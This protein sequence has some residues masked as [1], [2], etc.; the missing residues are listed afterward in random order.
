MGRQECRAGTGGSRERQGRDTSPKRSA[1]PPTCSSCH[2]QSDKDPPCS[3]MYCTGDSPW[4]WVP[5]S[6]PSRAKSLRGRSCGACRAR[7]QGLREAGAEHVLSHMAVPGWESMALT[8]L[9]SLGLMAARAFMPL[10]C[11]STEAPRGRSVDRSNTPTR[12]R[13]EAVRM[14]LAAANP[15]GPP[16]MI[17]T[18][19]SVCGRGGQ[20]CEYGTLRA[21]RH[22]QVCGARRSG[23][24]GGGALNQKGCPRKLA[25]SDKRSVSPPPARWMAR[26][27]RRAPSG[28]PRVPARRRGL[29]QWTAAWWDLASPKDARSGSAQCAACARPKTAPPRR[30]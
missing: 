2:V 14:A 25:G 1:H 19:R 15:P 6:V 5:V 18:S 20:G 8:P 7:R 16:P 4:A 29:R 3:L 24:R 27:Q 28:R 21:G 11:T 12:R 17:A 23:P 13:G 10:G 9:A 30:R 22:T 26:R